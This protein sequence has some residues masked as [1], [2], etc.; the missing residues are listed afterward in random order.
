MH[1]DVRAGNVLI[2]INV[3]AKL[4]NFN[5]SRFLKDDTRERE[6]DLEHIRYRAP[7]LLDDDEELGGEKLKYC[8]IIDVKFIALES[9]FGKLPKRESRMKILMIL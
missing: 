5:L 3:T 1:R 2:T 7:E 9:Y 6:D 8:M 4:T